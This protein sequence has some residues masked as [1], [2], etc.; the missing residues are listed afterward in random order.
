MSDRV[1]RGRACPPRG[2]CSRRRCATAAAGDG[3]VRVEDGELVALVLERTRSPGRRTR[4]RS[5]TA[6][7]RRCGP[8]RS[9]PPRPSRSED[10]P[11]R[12]VRRLALGVRDERVRALR[13]G[14]PPDGALHRLLD[15]VGVPEVG[16]EVLPAAVGEDRDDDALVEL[17]G[18]L[19]RDVDDGARRDAGEDAL[20]VE[21]RANR[22][23]PT[24][25]SRRAPCGRAS[26]RRG[27]AARSRPRASAGP[28]PDR[29]EAARPRRRRR[30]GTS[31]AAAR[32]CPSASRRC[33][34][35]RRA[36]STRSSAS[37][38]SAPVPS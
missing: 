31:R 7:R 9:A 4:A 22:A 8:A 37:A 6:T 3:D 33:R 29:P 36:T 25:R 34:G 20:L 19:A 11:A 32:R 12:L 13:P 16:G 18:E 14:S 26:R 35:R 17:V 28:S 5:G 21:Q 2:R 10:E 27:S 24:P 1:R 23:R 15:V 30:P 38:I